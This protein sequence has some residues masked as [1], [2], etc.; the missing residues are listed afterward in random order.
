MKNHRLLVLACFLLTVLPSAAFA[1][2]PMLDGLWQSDTGAVYRYVQ[3]GDTVVAIYEVLTEGQVAAG[4]KKGDLSLKGTYVD[5]VLSATFY[6]RAP[7]VIQTQCPEHQI[8]DLPVSWAF[9]DD[10]LSGSI[11]RVFGTDES[12]EIT[13]RQLQPMR[14]ERYKGQNSD[15][16]EPAGDAMSILWPSPS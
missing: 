15:K 9:Q 2:G 11:T 1:E 4:I 12:C 13:R 3:R 10:V 7:V 8:I 6:Q 16:A 5:N 14:L